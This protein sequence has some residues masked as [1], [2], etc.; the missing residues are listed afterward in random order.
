[1]PTLGQPIPQSSDGVAF[2]GGYDATNNQTAARQIVNSQTA[3]GTT[4]GPQLVVNSAKAGAVAAAAAQPSATTANTDTSW[5]FSQQVNHIAIQNN[6]SSNVYFELD[7]TATNGSFLLYPGQGY[8]QDV[9]CTTIHLLATSVININGS[10]AGN[11]VIR[12]W[13]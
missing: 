6:S 12:G 1:M 8:S 4:Y 9:M 13:Q 5:S 3:N 10:T 11:I 7:A 2:E